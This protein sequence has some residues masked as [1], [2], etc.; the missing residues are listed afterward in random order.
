MCIR[1]KCCDKKCCLERKKNCIE[2]IF[3]DTCSFTDLSILKSI[4]GNCD[5]KTTNISCVV[6]NNTKMPC[7]TDIYQRQK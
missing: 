2:L 1:M 3:N 4:W 6:L 5:I 7:I